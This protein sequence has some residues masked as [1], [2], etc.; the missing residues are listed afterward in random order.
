MHVLIIEDEITLA[1]ELQHF[2]VK[3]HYHCDL[4]LTGADA[5]EKIAVNLYDF[6]LLD[7]GLPDYEGLDLLA[8]ARQVGQEAAFIIL[9]ARGELDDRLK[10]LDLGADDYLAKPFSLLELQARMQAITRRKFGLKQTKLTIGRF[11]VDTNSYTIRHDQDNINLT[12]KEL[13]ILTYLLLHKNRV[14][15][16]LQLSE[17]IW[18]NILE[19]DYDS[20]YID[21][22]IKNIRKKLGIYADTAWLETVR[23]IGY[24]VNVENS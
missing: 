14:L 6:V 21:V 18:G 20:N 15:T 17:H 9:T 13:D 3:A 12:K 8:E 23:G 24:K 22:H 4:A 2:L 10:G 11:E 19:D 7:L 1:K 5:S 16:R